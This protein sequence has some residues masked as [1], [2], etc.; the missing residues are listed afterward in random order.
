MA[1][2]VP[3]VTTRVGQAQELVRDGKNGLLVDVG[4]VDALVA[5]ALGVHDDPAQ[6]ATF[7]GEGRVTAEMNAYERLD[8]RW[9]ALLEGFVG[10][11][12]A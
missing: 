5:A 4:D 12:R 11:R 8:D 9:A 7:R 10:A 6:A 1:T 3:L 2:G